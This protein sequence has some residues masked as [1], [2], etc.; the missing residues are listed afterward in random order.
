MIVIIGAGP[1][2][3]ATA[4]HLRRPATLVER[5]AEVGGL[6]RSFELAGA[7]FDLGGHAFFTHHEPVRELY[8]KVTPGGLF[9]QPRQAWVSSHGTF[10]PYPFQSN[11][12]GLPVDVVRDCLTGAVEAALSPPDEP[13]AT[14]GEWVDRAFGSGVA[15]HFLRP[16]NEKLWA[17]PL[18][19]IVPTWTSERVVQPP[20]DAMIDGAL[21]R[22]PYLDVPN[23]RVGYP[24]AGGFE[25]IFGGM[26]SQVAAPVIRGEVA[27]VDLDARQVVTS[28]G[29][30]VAF[31]EL[32]ST[33]PL[34][35][36]VRATPQAP[37]ELRAAVDRLLHNSLVLV[38][39]VV[40]RPAV[41]EMQRVYTADPTIPFHKLVV[42]TNSSP[43]LAANGVT[44][45]QG[46]VSSSP[47]KVLPDDGTLVA[48]TLD[49][50]RRLGLLGD[51]DAVVATSTTRVP[52]AYPVYTA[53]RAGIVE[54]ARAFYAAHGVH[55]VGRFAE[56]A[57]INSDEAVH[58]GTQLARRLDGD[59]SRGA[60][61]VVEVAS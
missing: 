20:L 29:T 10:L 27:T 23:A 26:A 35:A 46:E 17:H 28:D 4:L 34:P 51:G 25:A 56:W 57:Y 54:E 7:T 33:I 55:L 6:C 8:G 13:P 37:P 58:R 59:I 14:F 41:T 40:D 53:D 22:R 43:A 24:S 42:N 2:G 31:D 11:L 3:L 44:G 1:A 12:F 19:D 47:H 9:H 38:N 49:G 21:R 36:L 52:L 5:E 15:R 45:F 60:T 30:V 18:E 32:V 50:L 16:Y 48:G 61:G 39:V